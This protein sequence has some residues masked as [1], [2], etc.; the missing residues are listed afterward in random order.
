MFVCDRPGLKQRPN[1]NNNNWYSLIVEIQNMY[2]K[3][4]SE[5]HF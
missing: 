1:N 4:S 3:V 5:T 2:I